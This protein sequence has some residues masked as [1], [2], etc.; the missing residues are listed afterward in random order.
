MPSQYRSKNAMG[1]RPRRLALG[2]AGKLIPLEWD[3]PSRAFNTG[4]GKDEHSKREREGDA[5]DLSHWATMNKEGQHANSAHRPR[6]PF[7]RGS[8][9]R[10]GCIPAWPYPPDDAPHNGANLL[11]IQA[12]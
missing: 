1:P 12:V 3:A 2:E 6:R 11:F 4:C 7:H 9:W 5:L 10:S 8:A